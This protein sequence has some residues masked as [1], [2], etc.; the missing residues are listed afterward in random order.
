M[1]EITTTRQVRTDFAYL[2]GTADEHTYDERTSVFDA[3]LVEHDR[4]VLASHPDALAGTTVTQEADT[5]TEWG[6]SSRLAIDLQTRTWPDRAVDKCSSELGA[7][8]GEA[9]DDIFVAVRREVTDWRR[10]T[11]TPIARACDRGP[12]HLSRGHEGCCNPGGDAIPTG[13]GGHT[14]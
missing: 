5:H 8:E 4:Q 10:L 7:R 6:V 13:Q 12:C 14:A 2:G 9:Q 3:W 11:D 1:I